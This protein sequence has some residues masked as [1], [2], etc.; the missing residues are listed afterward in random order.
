MKD[1]VPMTRKEY[2][3]VERRGR[4]FGLNADQRHRMFDAVKEYQKELEGRNILDWGDVPQRLWKF[5]HQ[6]KMELPQYDFILIY[7]AQ[8]FAPVWISLI[9]KL[10]AP[11]NSHLFIVADPTQGFLGRGTSWKSLGLE[12]R[13][14]TQLI[15]RS[16]RTTREIMDFATLL[17]RRRLADEKDDDILAL[18]LLNMPNG[19][20]PQIIPRPVRRMR[21]FVLRTKWQIL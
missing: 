21:L 9:L 19:V 8:F 1:Q 7:E 6:G 18:D 17:Y 11:K 13:G 14:H 12:A 3:S 15:R 10:V 20:F 5:T 4:G 16:Y 2:L